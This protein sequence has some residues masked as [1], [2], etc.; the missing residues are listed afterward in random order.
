[1]PSNRNFP[2]IPAFQRVYFCGVSTR[3]E[4]TRI[5]VIGGG[6]AGIT[7]AW[8]LRKAGAEVILLEARPHLG[9][10]LTSHHP[11]GLPTP[12]DNGPHLFLSTYVLARRLFRELEIADSFV[13]P[14]PGKIQFIRR[15]GMRGVLREWP[16]PSPFN[17]A[18]GMLSLTLLPWKARLSILGASNDLLRRGAPAAE[19]AADWLSSR[20]AKPEREVFWHP[21]IQAALNAPPEEVPASYLGVIFKQGFCRGFTGGRLGYALRPLRELFGDQTRSKLEAAG[22]QVRLG[23]TSW[24]AR[25]SSTENPRITGVLVGESETI[26]AEAVV[27]ALPPWTLS[28]WLTFLY[29]QDD[30]QMTAPVLQPQHLMEGWQANPIVTIYLWADN[31]PL[32]ETFT[33]L[34]G[35][36]IAWVFDFARLWGDRRAPV[37][38]MLELHADIDLR[39]T[40]IPDARRWTRHRFPL[41]AERIFAEL[42][43]ALP[44]LSRVDWRAWKIIRERRATPLRPRSSWTTPPQQTTAIPNLLLAGDW[45]DSELPPTVEAAV[46]TGM[47]IPKLLRVTS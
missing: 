6:I 2:C 36:S 18:A 11:S 44:Q 7:A 30:G 21:L 15:D 13:F 10:R 39:D 5:V 28:D 38:L 45:L 9:G 22:I 33:S 8:E 19:S 34:P 24:G 27:A 43:S 41:D 17:L 4:F 47:A 14:Y 46:R 16:L 20:S 1:M 25:L 42:F 29:P 35:R 37:A 40:Q 3:G 23:T 32:L 12:F 31:R 26:P